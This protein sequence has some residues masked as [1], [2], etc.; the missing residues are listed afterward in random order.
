METAYFGTLDDG[1]VINKYTLTNRQGMVVSAIN[2]GGVI[3]AIIVPDKNGNMDD[4][5]LGYDNLDGYLNDSNYLGAI[6]GRCAN[7]IAGAQ[8]EID[9]RT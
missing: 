2:Y 7:R 4:V 3:T 8:F 5:V 6:V 1:H 9:G